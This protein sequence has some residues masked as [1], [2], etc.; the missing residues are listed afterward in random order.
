MHHED[1]KSTKA[2][3]QASP[4]RRASRRVLRVLSALCGDR[5][6]SF[7][8]FSGRVDPAGA[9]P[10]Y[11][12]RE[13]ELLGDVR[14]GDA[15]ALGRLYALT[16]DRLY[17]T[18]RRV[19]VDAATADD[20]VHDVY[21][22]VWTRRAGIPDATSAMAYL[23]VIARNLWRNQRARGS[24]LRRFLEHVVP[25]AAP[26]PSGQR[27]D[28]AQAL[29]TLEDEPREVFSLHRY[30]GLSYAEI[31]ALLGVAVKTVEARMKRAFDALRARLRPYIETERTC[32]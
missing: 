16:R 27:E 30:A 12:G 28:I 9:C 11:V 22:R 19:G 21:L 1:T 7:T 25:R 32:P 24:V 3:G 26:P 8:E 13:E 29:L 10:Q 6:G 23:C 5:P 18:V 17:S 2:M 20:L 14:T 4:P 15:S 31:A